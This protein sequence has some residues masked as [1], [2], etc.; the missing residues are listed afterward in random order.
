[1]NTRRAVVCGQATI[2]FGRTKTMRH[3]QQTEV[4][5]SHVDFTVSLKTRRTLRM[6]WPQPLLWCKLPPGAMVIATR[7]SVYA[8]HAGL[9]ARFTRF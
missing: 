5:T 7:S 9:V 1:M 2:C 4:R 6:V 3:T 8:Y